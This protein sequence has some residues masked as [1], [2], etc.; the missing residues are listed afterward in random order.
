VV[1]EPVDGASRST[2]NLAG[3]DL[4]WHSIDAI[5]HGLRLNDSPVRLSCPPG[6]NGRH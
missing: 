5:L 6:S 4:D 3:P 2:E 1:V